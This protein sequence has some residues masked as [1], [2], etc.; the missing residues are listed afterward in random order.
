MLDFSR[1]GGTN[2]VDSSFNP[3]EIFQALPKVSGKFQ[4]P[5]DVQ[6]QVWTKWYERRNSNNLVIKMNTGGGKTS[7]GLLVLKSCLNEKKGPAVYVVP[8]NYLVDQVVLEA[9]E[10]GIETTN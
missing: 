9:K 6:S 3:R 4:Y 1:L 8:D 5:R 7:V 10:L 2:P